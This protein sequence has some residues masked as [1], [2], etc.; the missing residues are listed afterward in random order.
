MIP[1]APNFEFYLSNLDDVF[2]IEESRGT[3]PDFSYRMRAQEIKYSI[4][5]SGDKIGTYTVSHVGEGLVSLMYEG[6]IPG[7]QN[8]SQIELRYCLSQ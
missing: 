8:N 5:L 4:S 3:G 6:F 2:C 1:F 7:Y